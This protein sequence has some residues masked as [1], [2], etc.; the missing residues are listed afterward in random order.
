MNNKG[1]L[2]VVTGP[3]FSGKTEE[4]IH[5]L[6]RAAIG[7]KRIQV[8]KHTIDTR[9]G[10][11]EKLYSHA[12]LTFTSSLITDAK[13]I[14]KRITTRS[15]IIAIDEAQWFGE[16]IV[17]VVNE[18]LRQKKH[19]LVSGL[20]LTFD[21]QPFHPMPALMAM[22]DKVTKL[23]AICSIC[24]DEAVFHKRISDSKKKLSAF[25]A[26]PSFVSKSQDEYQPRCRGCY[27]K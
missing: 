25:K 10:S 18:L 2:E 22:A 12:G 23:T 27:E 8:F 24:G 6:K 14:L 13:E 16:D 3:M 26:D 4:L 21:R 5:Q 19:I 20:A 1:Y 17:N 7:K 9:Y 15:H 11:D